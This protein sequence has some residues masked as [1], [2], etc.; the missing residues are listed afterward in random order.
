MTKRVI[1]IVISV[2]VLIGGALTALAGGA[3]MALFGSASTLTSG[4]ERAATATVALVAPMDNIKDTNGFAETVGQPKLS[5]S[6]NGIGRDVFIGIGPAAAVDSYLASAPIDKVTD[7]EIDPF[8]LKTQRQDGTAKPPGPA[9]QKFWIA[10][11][12]GPQASIDWKITDGS[13]RLVVMNSDA[14]PGVAIDGR[15]SLTVPH[16]FAIG[17]GILAA[18][19]IAILI[20]V[21]LLVLGLR[22][23]TA[24]PSGRG[25]TTS[26][27]PVAH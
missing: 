12:S 15:F 4:T 6:A 8:Q 24:P 5:L 2:L 10:Q 23:T 27:I 20:G 18:G 9:T 14:S 22:S 3:L 7:L 17:I 26:N 16:L 19:I 21:L 11:S 25:K 1:L 13:Y